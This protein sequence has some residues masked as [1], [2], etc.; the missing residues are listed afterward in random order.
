MMLA[1]SALLLIS[2]IE[3]ADVRAG[4]TAIALLLSQQ[5]PDLPA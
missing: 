5:V 2:G 3:G 1:L 4:V